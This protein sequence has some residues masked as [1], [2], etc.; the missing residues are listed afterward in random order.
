M[1]IALAVPVAV[2]LHA[3]GLLLAGQQ[4]SFEESKLQ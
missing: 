1:Y 3:L 4:L 2:L